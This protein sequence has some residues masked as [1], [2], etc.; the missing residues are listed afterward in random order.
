[1]I[2]ETQVQETPPISAGFHILKPNL[3]KPEPLPN[4]D[5]KPRCIT[6]KL[7]TC[8]DKHKDVRRLRLVH[9]I[10]VSRPGRDQFAFRVQENG[11]MYEINFPNVTTGLTETLIHKL[12]GMMGANNISIS[13]I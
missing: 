8:G 2:A 9:D 7:S 1:V 10:L 12:E 6:I 3:P 4:P 11:C 5:Q 13:H